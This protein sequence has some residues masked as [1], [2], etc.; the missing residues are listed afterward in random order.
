MMMKIAQYPTVLTIAGSDSGGGAGIQADLKTISALGCYGS[1]VIT[2]LTAQNTI[3]VQGIHSIPATFVKQQ[4]ESVLTDI[5]PDAIKIGMVHN[6]ELVETI[7]CVL[8]KYPSIPVVFDPVMIASSGDRLIEESTVN[9]IIEALFPAV[10][11]ITPNMDEAALLAGMP[12]ETLDH[13]WQAGEKI[14]QLGCNALLLKGGHLKTKKL[15]SLLFQKNG[16]IKTFESSYIDSNNTHGSGCTLSSA[17]ASFLALGELLPDAIF[18]AQDYVHEAILYGR[19]V[20]TGKG[21]GP[22]N[23][24]YNPKKLTAKK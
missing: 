22:L 12:V 24:F 1:S 2:A 20:I 18:H 4:L 3:G 17:I 10:T 23:H 14:M 7:A 11:L 21:T 13:M 16:G 15:T 9:R 19:N 6:N 8:K 5:V